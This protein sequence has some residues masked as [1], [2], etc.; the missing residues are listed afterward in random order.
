MI[1]IERLD[2]KVRGA[3]YRQAGLFITLVIL[4]SQVAMVTWENRVVHGVYIGI[5]SFFFMWAMGWVAFILFKRGPKGVEKFA[6]CFIIEFIVPPV[7][8]ILIYSN[9]FN[10]IDNSY[11][12]A[13]FMTVVIMWVFMF[14]GLISLRRRC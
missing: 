3:L 14:I 7:S 8:A 4:F 9:Y 6:D 2:E 1:M 10:K 12:I 13:F 5:A 11:L